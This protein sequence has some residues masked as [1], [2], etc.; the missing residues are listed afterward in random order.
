MHYP[1]GDGTPDKHLPELYDLSRDPGE[2]H[3][4]AADPQFAPIRRQ[5]EEKLAA[6]LTAAGLG[7]G[8]DKMPP[9]EGIKS[10]LPDQK[11]R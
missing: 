1:P 4:L 6:M 7:G 9:D 2:L 10:E 3:N 5:L 11:I 8:K